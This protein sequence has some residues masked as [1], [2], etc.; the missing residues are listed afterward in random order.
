MNT[1]TSA[2]LEKAR[3]ESEFA[4]G[5]L[6]RQAFIAAATAA[7]LGPS[8]AGAAADEIS[9]IK[10]NQEKLRGNLRARYHYIV[11]GAGSS[12]SVI[13]RRL[14]EDPNTEV[15]L[16]EAGGS[17]DSVAIIDPLRWYMNI[18]G[19]FDWAYKAEASPSLNGRSINLPMGKTLGGGSSINAMVWARGHKND[20]NEWAAAVDDPA[21]N[22]ESVLKV[23]RRIE[24][25]QGTPDPSRRGQGGLVWV[26]PARK[27][28]ELAPAMVR[29]AASI[30]ITP[31][32]DHN[33]AMM[34]GDGGCAVAN[35]RIKDGLRVSVSTTYLKPVMHQPN[36]TV[37]TDATVLR[38]LLENKRA[39]GIEFL[40]EG[41]VRKVSVSRDVILS[42]GAM[43]TPH[44]LMLSGIGDEIELKRVGLPTIVNLPGV[45][46][47]FQDHT[48]AGCL[49]EPNVAIPPRNNSAEAT[50]F[51]KSDSKLPTPDIQ[52]FLIEIPYVSEVTGPQFNPPATCWS[53]AAAVV[54]PKSRGHLRLRSSNPMEKIAVFANALEH[55]DDLRAL[56]RSVELVRDLGNSGPMK[57]LVKREIMPASLRGRELDD[58]IRN[59]AVS[60]NH[61]TC[62]CKMGTDTESVVDGKLRV[63]GIDNLRIADGSIMPNITTGNTMAP[64]VIIGERMAEILTGE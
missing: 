38:V 62:T 32:D 60:Y 29:A 19:E 33:G 56:R 53:I 40:L 9:N 28:S 39:T 25:W 43:Q 4:A 50:F 46:K 47:N 31:F 26:E 52:P 59:G 3:L 20:F 6:D 10:T 8:V 16:L 57:E 44:V 30:G 41:T 37:L 45:G 27:P 7:G 49:W 17:D 61:A 24:D 1:E 21:W 22:Y 48:M 18:G 14:A 42:M 35:L 15:L 36:L 13:A 54:R 34:E 63:R 12:G 2:R 5:R 23:Y 64:C 11:C 55:E 51:W 58:F